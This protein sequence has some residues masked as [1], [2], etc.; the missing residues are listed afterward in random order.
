LIVG[1]DLDQVNIFSIGRNNH[2]KGSGTF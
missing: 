1:D 2:P